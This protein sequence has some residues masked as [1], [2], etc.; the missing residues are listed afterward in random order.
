MWNGY[1]SLDKQGLEKW[2]LIAEQALDQVDENATFDV[3]ASLLWAK[4][5]IL[6]E[7]EVMGVHGQGELGTSESCFAM[8]LDG[9]ADIKS[10]KF[11][12]PF[13]FYG[14]AVNHYLKGEK[15]GAVTALKKAKE[16]SGFDFENRLNL[17][18]HLAL[19]EI[20]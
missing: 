18:I 9:E 14:V 7:L 16:Y 12:V 11:L 15:E 8:I 19:T 3:E 4:G 1:S 5:C 17:R 13:T 20:G 6:Q 10:D 2:L